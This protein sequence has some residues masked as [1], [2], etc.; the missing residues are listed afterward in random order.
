MKIKL[1]NT[2]DVLRIVYGT[3]E[4]FR[5]SVATTIITVVISLFSRDEKKIPAQDSLRACL[6][7]VVIFLLDIYP[8][9]TFFKTV[10]SS[11]LWYSLASIYIPVSPSLC[12]PPCFR[13]LC[14]PMSECGIQLV[15]PHCKLLALELLS[16]E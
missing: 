7:V 15:Y 2:C 10:N 6:N 1:I 9:I 8:S 14:N 11:V 4:M 12:F 3:W 5:S 13:S 16:V